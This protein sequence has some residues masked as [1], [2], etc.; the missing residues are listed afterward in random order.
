VALAIAWLLA[1]IGWPLAALALATALVV[2]LAL[3][4]RDATRGALAATSNALLESIAR[5][6]TAER[7]C[8]ELLEAISTASIDRDI[9][10]VPSEAMVAKGRQAALLLGQ[11]IDALIELGDEDERRAREGAR[12]DA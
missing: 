3:G 4:R 6:R 12:H 5:Q 11:M 9:T 1:A 8:A 10:T 7:W 2:G